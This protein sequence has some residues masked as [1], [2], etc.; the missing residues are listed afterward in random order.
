MSPER[1]VNIRHVSRE[2]IHR[3]PPRLIF[4]EQFR[5]RPPSRLILEIDIRQRLLVV[6][7]HDKAG[8]LFF[9]GP[10]GREAAGKLCVRDQRKKRLL[11]PYPDA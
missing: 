4:G 2:N 1:N 3:N 5:R 9:D 8:G 11:G 10:R 7:A 6:I